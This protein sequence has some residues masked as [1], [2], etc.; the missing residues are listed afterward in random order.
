M[1]LPNGFEILEDGDAS[2]SSSSKFEMLEDGDAPQ[3]HPQP[4]VSQNYSQELYPPLGQHTPNEGMLVDPQTGVAGGSSVVGNV[5][6]NLAGSA[7]ETGKMIGHNANRAVL[8]FADQTGNTSSRPF[9]YSGITSQPAKT[10]EQ[11]AAESAPARDYEAQQAAAAQSRIQNP[12]MEMAGQTASVMAPMAA[13]GPGGIAASTILQLN[14]AWDSYERAARERG[15]PNPAASA[16]KGMAVA[17]PF[18][19]ASSAMP[20]AK[21]GFFKKFLANTTMFGAQNFGNQAGL[22]AATGQKIDPMQLLT[23]TAKGLPVAAVTAGLHSMPEARANQRFSNAWDMQQE[24]PSGNPTTPYLRQDM[25]D[26]TGFTQKASPAA[27]AAPF[28]KPTPDL[29]QPSTLGMN[30]AELL[31][32]MDRQGYDTS[33]LQDSGRKPILKALQDQQLARQAQGAMQAHGA[34]AQQAGAEQPQLGPDAASQDSHQ[35]RVFARKNGYQVDETRVAADV[36]RGMSPREAIRKQIE[37]Q[38]VAAPGGGLLKTEPST[39]TP[40]SVA[41]AGEQLPPYPKNVPTIEQNLDQQL[42]QAPPVEKP[43]SPR[44]RDVLAQAPAPEEPLPPYPKNVPTVEENIDQRLEE[45]SKAPQEAA[46]PTPAAETAVQPAAKQ[47]ETPAQPPPAGFFSNIAAQGRARIAELAGNEEGGMKRPTQEDVFGEGSIAKEEIAPLVKQSS[48]LIKR[49]FDA[50]RSTFPREL[51]AGSE[52]TEANVREKLAQADNEHQKAMLSL[53]GVR[54]QFNAMPQEQQHDFM[55]NMY[56]NESQPTPELQRVADQMYKTTN[57]RRQ[58]I[59]GLGVEA[60]KA[61]DENHWNMMWEPSGEE[62]APPAGKISG[63]GKIEGKAGTLRARTLS[64]WDEGIQHGLKP[65][66]DNPIEMFEAT[67]A[68]QRRFI[69][70]HKAIQD[71]ISDGT[72]SRQAGALAPGFR[73]LDPRTSRLYSYLLPQAVKGVKGL[74]GRLVVPDGDGRIIENMTKPSAFAGSVT[75][76]A[77]RTV[78]NTLTQ[79]LL[80]LSGNHLRKIAQ[81]SFTTSLGSSIDNLLHGRPMEALQDAK[82]AVLAPVQNIFR[83]G[84]VQRQMLGLE[85]VSPEDQATIDLMSRSMRAKPDPTYETQ[86]TAKMLRAW[87]QGGIQGSLRAM[88]YAPPAALEQLSKKVIFNYVQRAKLA[89]GFKQMQQGLAELGPNASHMDK[90]QMA[91]RVSDHMDNIF[92]LLVRDNLFWNRTARDVGSLSMLSTGWNYGSLREAVGA[93]KDLASIGKNVLT[94]KGSGGV[95][96]RRISY[97]MASAATQATLGAAMTYLATGKGPQS[98]VD[99]AFPPTGNKDQDGNAERTNLGFYTSDWYEFANHPVDTVANKASPLARVAVGLLTNKDAQGVRIT[100]P[101]DELHQKAADIATYIAKQGVPISIQQLTRPT[102][103]EPSAIR[104]YGQALTGVRAAPKEYSRSNAENLLNTLQQEHYEVGGRTA[105][106]A[107]RSARVSQHV[108]DLRNDVPGTGDRISDEL[109]EGK[110][111]QADLANIQSRLRSPEGIAGSITHTQIPVTDLMRVWH[112]ATA[113]E[114]D[115]IRD[116]L[117][118]K[119]AGTGELTPEQKQAFASQLED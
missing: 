53:E 106:Q 118:K 11:S 70:G 76:D 72:I 73:E 59:A 115:Q 60:A 10:L 49:A 37:E 63:P 90:L 61:W 108:S 114:K 57:D 36:D 117:L 67:D 9:D 82:G 68:E 4:Q 30:N 101:D 18:I 97:V 12:A 99:Y 109:E 32:E 3:Q 100:Q 7:V 55:R 84:Q 1:P 48:R 34:A 88:G 6:R 66:Y 103:T 50:V 25:S 23:E 16:E 2:P 79:G 13:G 46:K 83:G 75:M 80:G 24:G 19:I 86:F 105:E 104:K 102:A 38:Y 29:T 78:N 95:D 85:H 20:G 112:V 17:A 8:A 65:K 81:E 62:P 31:A 113:A 107:A 43:L 28:P 21:G 15:D 5:F 110:L 71:M 26:I 89:E 92:G 33:Q 69:A 52:E 74:A 93:G 51:G 27:E 45:E 47:A 56:N 39:E 44:V 119:L 94:G 116:P 58:E 111:T 14:D 22:Q 41:Q 42:E 77:A 87:D 98:L 91:G 96:T 35:L 54:R 40:E 64:D